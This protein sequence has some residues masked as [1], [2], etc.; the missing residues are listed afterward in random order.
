MMQSKHV[1]FIHGLFMNPKSWESWKACFE[2]QGYT[3]HAPAFPYHEGNPADLRRKPDPGL[4]SITFRDVIDTLV[5]FIDQLP[6]KPI[7][8]G[9]SVGALAVQKLINLE[10]GSAGICINS[11][12]PQFIFT[13]TWSFVT[14]N[15]PVINPF[16]GN[17]IFHPTVDWFHG[18]FCNTMTKDDAEKEFNK[19][20]VPESRNIPRSITGSQGAIDFKKPHVPLLLTSGDRD[21]IVPADLN[22]KNHKAYSGS[23]GV[24]DYV[25]FQGRSHYICGQPGW[26]EVAD[27][28]LAWLK[29]V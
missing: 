17:T 21:T 27:Y 13:T 8:I 7:L 20:V 9:H 1:V 10:K 14:T 18:A 29:K 26:E 2:A 15:L 22:R 6:E 12:P 5:K 25:S 16:R 23:V 3:C 4:S 28:C 19:F 24:T 11:A